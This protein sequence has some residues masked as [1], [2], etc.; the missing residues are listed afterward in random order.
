M[1][2]GMR[3]ENDEIEKKI[4]ERRQ[5]NVNWTKKEERKNESFFYGKQA[6]HFCVASPQGI[7]RRFCA[8]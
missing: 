6:K 4:E 2:C 8:S 1:H 5:T 3:W 7:R